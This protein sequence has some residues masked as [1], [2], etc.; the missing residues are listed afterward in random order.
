[1]LKLVA[2]L[3]NECPHPPPKRKSMSLYQALIWTA[4]LDW[5]SNLTLIYSV[6]LSQL[7]FP[8]CY[9]C[10]LVFLSRTTW[11][12]LLSMPWI[13]LLS[14]LPVIVF[15]SHLNLRLGF[16]KEH[17]LV[18][19]WKCVNHNT[20]ISLL[21]EKYEIRPSSKQNSRIKSKF[22]WNLVL[23]SNRHRRTARQPFLEEGLNILMTCSTKREQIQWATWK[24]ATK[25]TSHYYLFQT[26]NLKLVTLLRNM[27]QPILWQNGAIFD[28]KKTSIC[29][30]G[31]IVN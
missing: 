26:V 22:W 17:C 21:P 7:R 16:W 15:Y 27:K 5:N 2:E 30:F 10:V 13:I 31:A 19:C 29:K 23:Y 6:W 18:L 4:A 11:T 24:S 14:Y 3:N 28:F 8:E 9:D 20:I 1:M 12:V 25:L